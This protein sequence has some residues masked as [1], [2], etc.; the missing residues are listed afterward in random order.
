MYAYLR[1][2]DSPNGK[3]GSP[4]YV[5]VAGSVQRP[6]QLHGRTPVPSDERRVRVLRQ[7]VTHEQAREWE[8]Y[9]IE[10][11]G[12]KDVG[13][14]RRM[15][16]NRTDGGDGTARLNARTRAKIGSVHRGVPKSEEHKAKLRVTSS[17]RTPE[18]RA[19]LRNAQLGK[20][21]SAETRAK[22]SASHRG[23]TR[24]AEARAKMAA[25][26]RARPPEAWAKV[27][28][29]NR[30]R[31]P[32]HRARLSD[33][34]TRRSASAHGVDHELWIKIP[35]NQRSNAP[36]QA[37]K[38]GITVAQYIEKMRPKWGI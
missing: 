10:K 22:M 25:A 33:A 16:M 18:T 32:E 24:S 27:N 37:R 7:G 28:E 1:D 5:G 3:A 31:T 2:K 34:L 6:Y 30:N 17:N 36:S 38:Q 19:K 26:V 20:K 13:T 15:L 35:R 23:K 8:K 21:H 12:R 29:V 9:Y 14:G 11:F 4:Y